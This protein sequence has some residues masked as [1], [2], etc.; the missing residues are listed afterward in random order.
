MGCSQRQSISKLRFKAVGTTSA[1]IAMSLGYPD[2]EHLPFETLLS[3]LKP[4]RMPSIFP[5]VQI[6]KRVTAKHRKQSLKTQNKPT[7]AGVVGI[8]IEDGTKEPCRPLCDETLME[9]K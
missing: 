5:S 1:G 8:N 7:A 4:S 6:L 3:V 9:E 2:G